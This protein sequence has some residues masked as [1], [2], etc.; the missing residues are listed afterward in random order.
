MPDRLL[1]Q[2]GSVVALAVM[3][4]VSGTALADEPPGP[5]FQQIMTTPDDI[6]RN[7]AYARA[8]ARAGNLLQAAAALERILLVAPNENGI[9][10]FYVAVL[11]RLDDLQG[12]DQQLNALDESKLTPLQK[13]EAEKY[14]GLIGMGRSD[15]HYFGYIETG[16]TTDSDVFGALHTQFDFLGIP[17]AKK[18][19]QT[20]LNGGQLDVSKEINTDG[21]LSVFATGTL[22][23][24]TSIGGPNADYLN[25]E[26]DLGLTGY[27]LKYNW[28]VGGLVRQYQIIDSPFLSEYGGNAA[29]N[30]RWSPSL[31]LIGVF[32]GVEQNY[33]EPLIESLA[34]V[35][36]GTRDG[37]R[38]NLKGG[39]AYRFNSEN[40]ISGLFGYEV[41]TAGYEP[42]AYR[43]PIFDGDFHSL[44]GGGGY[45]DLSGE[46][47]NF[48]YQKV[49]A[50][51]FG[52]IR[53]DD[54]RG[55]L[56]MAMGAPLSAFTPAKATGDFREKILV[57]GA[58][59]YDERT[60]SRPIAPYSDIGF[61]MRLIWKF[62]E[63]R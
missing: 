26:F 19:G 8:Q 44:F 43:S 18:P 28:E 3:L 51:F 46:I 30:W 54:V 56:R 45:F 4:L 21:D 15:I 10:L 36:G 29:F 59:T 37:E 61:E 39:V 34:S 50:V 42:F 27:G 25:P 41:K 23:S 24:R 32:E 55:Y 2:L 63:S 6:A 58:V 57:E 49:D 16:L 62:G 53:R 17:A 12:A 31:T 52:G 14:R 7:F 48:N 13:S 22:Y 5:D 1:S 11:Y 33:H 40:S 38:Y 9:R 60:S 47:R 35:L 20:A